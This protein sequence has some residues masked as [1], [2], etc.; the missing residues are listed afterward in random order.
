MAA[1]S[2]QAQ[3]GPPASLTD[4]GRL[5]DIG[6]EPVFSSNPFFFKPVFFVPPR[7]ARGVINRLSPGRGDSHFQ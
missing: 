7:V 3:A 4:P 2:L 5:Q 1:P 6:F